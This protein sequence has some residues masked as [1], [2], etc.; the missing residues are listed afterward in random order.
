MKVIL[1]I[2]KLL[3]SFVQRTSLRFC[4]LWSWCCIALN[5]ISPHIDFL[6]LYS[7]SV[8]PSVSEFSLLSFWHHPQY[9][10]KQNFRRVLNFGIICYSILLHYVCNLHT[11][12]HVLFCLHIQ[13]V[14]K[15]A[16]ILT[17]KHE[18]FTAI[19]F[20][21]FVW[22]RKKRIFQASESFRFYSACFLGGQCFIWL[23]LVWRKWNY[24]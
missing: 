24:D 9:I 4:W 3:I 21:G 1:I 12:M 2:V 19:Y 14:E 5:I 17:V 6:I 23:N 13:C 11:C 22:R 18:T 8:L 10:S 20:S 15:L 16:I 7:L